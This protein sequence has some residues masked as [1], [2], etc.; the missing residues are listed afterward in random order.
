M[1]K[2]EDFKSLV[3]A[4]SN[5]PTVPLI[6]LTALLLTGLVLYFSKFKAK[7]VSMKME[8]KEEDHPQS[9]ATDLLS[10]STETDDWL[11]RL[12]LGLE[13]TRA[14][15]IANLESLFQQSH[16]DDALLKSLHETLYRA[17]IGTKAVDRLVAHIQKLMKSNAGKLKWEDIQGSLSQEIESILDLPSPKIEAKPRVILVVGVN[18]A[19]KTTTI[20]KLAAH[21][22]A[23]NK[24]VLIGAADTFRA[25]AIDQLRVWGDRLGV[26][27]IAHQE[28][29]D[30]AAVAFDSVQAA[31][32]RGVDVLLIDTAGRL[33]NKQ[34]LMNEL[35]KM[36]R[37]IKKE[38]PDAPHETL[39][40]LDATTG[41]N[42][43]MQVRAFRELAKIT[44]IC[45]TKLDGTAKGGVII[46][47]ANEFQIPIQYIGVGEKSSDFR[48]F[49]AKEF[50]SS[51]F[52]KSSPQ[53]ES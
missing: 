12:R 30:A 42:A 50:V 5:E 25:A 8:K 52:A 35:A 47:L 38:I 22:Q 33:H 4:W 11:G 9:E 32:S 26:K 20:A 1:N 39:L 36:V 19:G 45:V 40:V 16:T 28:G 49:Q 24:S 21:F 43:F 27:V 31:I 6:F 48:H 10:K 23:E 15:L 17:E 3:T 34:D 29:G 13:K 2:T 44:G 41:Q 18:G 51:L 46:G 14:S 37:V 53:K 7:K